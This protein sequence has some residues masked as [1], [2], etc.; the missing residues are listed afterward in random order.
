MIRKSIWIG[1]ALSLVI[2]GCSG[3]AEKKTE[4]GPAGSTSGKGEKVSI[5]VQAF[6]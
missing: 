5:E 6:K 4:E 2:S 1:L 3:G